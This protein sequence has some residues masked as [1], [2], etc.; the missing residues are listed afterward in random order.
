M[1]GA[2]IL[3][4]E[5]NKLYSLGTDQGLLHNQVY[6]LYED[7]KGRIWISSAGGI[8]IISAD[9]NKIQSINAEQG[10]N[11]MYEIYEVFEDVE[12]I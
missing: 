7:S 6:N 4:R 2:R 1:G 10:L 9:G 8:N 5:K 11:D 12:L 3:D